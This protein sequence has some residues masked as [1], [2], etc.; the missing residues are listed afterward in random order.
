MKIRFPIMLRKRYE[1]DT[2]KL[3]GNIDTLTQVV[4]SQERQLNHQAAVIHEMDSTIE[5][6]GEALSKG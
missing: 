5:V 4:T 2:A 3:L 6:M 1:E